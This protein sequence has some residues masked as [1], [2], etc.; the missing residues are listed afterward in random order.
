MAQQQKS[1]L[2]DTTHFINFLEKTKVPEN[3]ILVS[4]DVMS[5][6]TNIPQDELRI[7]IKKRTSYPYTTTAKNAQTYPSAELLPVY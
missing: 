3:T 1:Y 2:K 4:M 6:C 5:L 7:N